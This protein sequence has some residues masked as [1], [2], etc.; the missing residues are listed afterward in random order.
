[1]NHPTTLAQHTGA[2]GPA[3]TRP[4]NL[5]TNPKWM[6]IA[7][8]GNTMYCGAHNCIELGGFGAI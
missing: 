4:V 5:S 3:A 7:D 1:M 2:A 6:V 8:V